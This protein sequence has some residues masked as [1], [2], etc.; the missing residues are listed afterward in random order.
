MI[1]HIG[2]LRERAA[3]L[4]DLARRAPDIGDA[5]HRLADELDMKAAELER[6][7]NDP[8]VPQTR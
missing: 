5:L 7:W 3:A 4:R 8:P 1:S 2:F 6:S